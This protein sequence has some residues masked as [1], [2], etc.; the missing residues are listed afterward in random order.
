MFTRR[1]IGIPSIHSILVGSNQRNPGTWM[2]KESPTVIRYYNHQPTRLFE[3]VWHTWFEKNL[4]RTQHP[5]APC[6]EYLPTFTIIYPK[7]HPNV[8]KYTIHGS[9][10]NMLLLRTLILI[11]LSSRI[12]TAFQRIRWGCWKYAGLIVL[13]LQM[14][15]NLQCGAPKR[16]R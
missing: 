5:Y 16:Y 8:G 9:Y 2:M 7:N 14:S 4:N 13:A 10:G 1:F 3:N 15:C 6:M 12:Q 11:C